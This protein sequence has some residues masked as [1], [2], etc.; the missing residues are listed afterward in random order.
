MIQFR[1]WIKK[2][3]SAVRNSKNLTIRPARLAAELGISF[4]DASAELCGLLA[5]VGGGEGGASFQFEKAEMSPNPGVDANED[6]F[7]DAEGGRAK[8]ASAMSMVFKFPKDF[9]TR[10]GAFRRREDFRS[11]CLQNAKIGF[12]LLKAVVD[13][14]E[15][16]RLSDNV[17]LQ[18]RIPV[19]LSW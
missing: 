4:D 10:A 8:V 3:V 2:V 13:S 17:L 5:A 6:A 12:K 1:I 19:A 18:K 7:E 14:W 15:T 11:T 16:N 9:E